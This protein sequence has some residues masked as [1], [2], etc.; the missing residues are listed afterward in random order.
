MNKL[1]EKTKYMKA[2]DAFMEAVEKLQG[3]TDISSEEKKRIID[4]ARTFLDASQ[5][6]DG[7]SNEKI[8][9]T[10]LV[11]ETLRRYGIEFFR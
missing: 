10:I 5:P 4:I 1:T 9:D 11:S 2:F 3:N 8:D 7:L 6:V